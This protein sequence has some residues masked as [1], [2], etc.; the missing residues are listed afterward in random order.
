LEIPADD[1][2]LRE[3]LNALYLPER[4]T[5]VWH[6]DSKDLEVIWTALPVA[7]AWKDIPGR[8]FKFRV[9]GKEYDCEFSKSSDRVVHIAAAFRPLTASDTRFR[10]LESFRTHA[11]L[12]GRHSADPERHPAPY[13]EPKSFWIK[14]VEWDEDAVLALANILNF[15]LTYYDAISAYVVIHAPADTDKLAPQTRFPAGT[16][17]KQIDARPVDDVLLQ[18]WMASK[19]G[20][21]AS[22][23]LYGFRIIEY[24][25]FTFLD[26]KARSEIRKILAAPNAMDEIAAVTERVVEALQKST[27]DDF[28]KCEALLEAT[29]NPALLWREISANMAAF[30]ETITFDGGFVLKPLVSADATAT[31][32]ATKGI[33][34]F[35]RSIREIR[36]ALAH[37]RDVRTAGVITPTVRNFRKLTPWVTLISVAAGEVMLLRNVI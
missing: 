29:V 35:H 32:F 17:P 10:N 28:P 22:R 25:S 2:A 4:F 6:K 14:N 18:L 19:K 27:L 24:A 3:A 8:S 33:Q 7:P 31:T 34:N 16:F 37:G 13:T 26:S 9:A 15:Y 1:A 12:V 11:V 21:P 36:N 20:D 23:F 30:S 5:A